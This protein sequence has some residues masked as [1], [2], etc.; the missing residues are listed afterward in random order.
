MTGAPGS[1]KSTLARQ[2]SVAI[3]VPFLARDDIRGG[4]LF[5]EGAW[6]D[7]LERKPHLNRR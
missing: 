7:A 4:L 1:G 2:L 5:T 6:G 3:R